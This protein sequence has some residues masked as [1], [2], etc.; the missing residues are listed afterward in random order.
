[1]NQ[2]ES[3]S[4]GRTNGVNQGEGSE[5]ILRV[6]A[7]GDKSNDKVRFCYVCRD[8]GYPHEAIDFQKIPGRMLGNGTHETAGWILKDYTTGNRHVHKQ[9]RP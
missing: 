4:Y 7:A 3:E 5:L 8:S 2:H 9:R 1:M 6:A